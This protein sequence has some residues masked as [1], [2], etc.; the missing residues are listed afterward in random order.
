M[1]LYQY[2]LMATSSAVNKLFTPQFLKTTKLLSKELPVSQWF[3]E[4]GW[5]NKKTNI[6]VLIPVPVRFTVFGKR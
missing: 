4:L 2:I 1:K 5:V 6:P 3:N